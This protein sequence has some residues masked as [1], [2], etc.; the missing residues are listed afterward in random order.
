[1]C[2]LV[3]RQFLP[4]PGIPV[5]GNISEMKVLIHGIFEVK[6]TPENKEFSWRKRTFYNNVLDKKSVANKQWFT[7]GQCIRVSFNPL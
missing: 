2:T 5:Q 1:M 7:C 4:I 6:I 3:S